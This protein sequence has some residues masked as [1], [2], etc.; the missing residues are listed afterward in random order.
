MGVSSR[1]ALVG[2]DVPD[3]S[4]GIRSGG[5]AE[6]TGLSG[7]SLGVCGREGRLEGGADNACGGVVEA[8]FERVTVAERAGGATFCTTA[9]RVAATATGLRDCCPATPSGP[10]FVQQYIF[11]TGVVVAFALFP[12]VNICVPRVL[13]ETFCTNSGPWSRNQRS[14]SLSLKSGGAWQ[15][16]SIVWPV[17]LSLLAAARAS[18]WHLRIMRS[19]R[20]RI[21]MRRS[22]AA[23]SPRWS[24]RISARKR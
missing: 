15:V 4:L 5:R 10:H 23:V 19:L 2:V 16:K 18:R 22:H 8:L 17:F 13:A 7:G 3:G 21:W 9:V 20:C 6:R 24:S 11:D 1:S 14:I 12:P